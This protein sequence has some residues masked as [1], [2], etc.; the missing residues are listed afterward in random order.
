MSLVTFFIIYFSNK[1]LFIG[2]SIKNLFVNGSVRTGDSTEKVAC[3][4]SPLRS[5]PPGFVSSVGFV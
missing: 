5:S 2:F 3:V 1:N 4:G